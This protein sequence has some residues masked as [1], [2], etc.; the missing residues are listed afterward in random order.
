MNEIIA[1]LPFSILHFFQRISHFSVL[2]CFSRLAFSANPFFI[3]I[4]LEA[5]FP[6]PSSEGFNKLHVCI[7]YPIFPVND[8]N[9]N[10]DLVKEIKIS[11]LLY[12]LFFHCCSV[13]EESKTFVR[14]SIKAGTLI[15]FSK[16]P[17]GSGIFESGISFL[18]LGPL[19]L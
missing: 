7:E 9:I 1:E 17:A 4:G 6:L 2:K 16:N 10:W 11:P 18:N 3:F 12:I 5:L 14:N 13:P 19:K 15:G 8:G